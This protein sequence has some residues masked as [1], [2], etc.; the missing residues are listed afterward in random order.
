MI[1]SPAIDKRNVDFELTEVRFH[2]IMG[3]YCRFGHWP[4]ALYTADWWG[5]IYHT[6]IKDNEPVQPTAYTGPRNWN[7]SR[8]P[9]GFEVLPGMRV[10]YAKL[11]ELMRTETNVVQKA[12]ENLLIQGQGICSVA[13]STK[14]STK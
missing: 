13:W 3:L 14:R 12:C 6:E 4:I 7:A 5:G 11:A 2:P 9:V 1:S 10:P 8:V